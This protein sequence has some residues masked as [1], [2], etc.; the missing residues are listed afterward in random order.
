MVTALELES[1]P[2]HSRAVLTRAGDP[3]AHAASALDRAAGCLTAHGNPLSSL[4]AAEDNEHAAS[5]DGFVL[6]DQRGRSTRPWHARSRAQLRARGV[7]V[8]RPLLVFLETPPQQEDPTQPWFGPVR[9][10]RPGFPT[11]KEAITEQVFGR[12]FDHRD[13]E[14]MAMVSR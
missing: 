7:V 9:F 6:R 1:L 11:T 5:L 8:Q 14:S 4:V 13:P 2:A 10:D 3:L 12:G